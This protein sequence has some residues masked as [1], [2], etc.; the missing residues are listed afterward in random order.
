MTHSPV[1]QLPKKLKC[2]SGLMGG[3]SEIRASGSLMW[4]PNLL[5]SFPYLSIMANRM[6]HRIG[7]LFSSYKYF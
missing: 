3:N 2:P 4:I 6:A 5:N 7:G 1:L